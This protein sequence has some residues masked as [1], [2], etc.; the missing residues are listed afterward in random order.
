VRR[1]TTAVFAVVLVTGS[2]PVQAAEIPPGFAPGTT[3]RVSVN[4]AGTPVGSVTGHSISAN[5]RYVVFT[6]TSTNVVPG[7]SGFQVYRHDRTT[8]VTE[9]VSDDLD[10]HGTD[11]A[12][13]P[14]ISAD[15]R[16][17]AYHSFDSNI[18][19]GDT[20]NAQDVFVRDME[21]GVTTLVSSTPSGAFADRG[22]A[23][24]S[25]E[26]A[27]AISDD[28]RYVVFGSVSTNLVA[29]PA[30]SFSQV[31]RKDT[32]TGAVLRVSIDATGQP[33]NDISNGA[34]ISGN[35][36]VIA[37]IS[38]ASNFSPLV[39]N[40]SGQVYVH[41]LD[42]GLTTID[43]VNSNGVPVPSFAS[44]R[45]GLSVDGRYLVF[46]TQ[47]RMEARDLDSFTWDVYLRDRLD[48]TTRLASLSA[49]TFTFADS[50]GATISWDGRY[51]GFESID[52]GLVQGDENDAGD[53]FLYDRDTEN[54]TLVSL[55]DAGQQTS[56]S[57]SPSL[58]ADG[59]LVLFRSAGTNLV[60]DPPSTGAQLYVRDLAANAPPTVAITCPAEVFVIDGAPIIGT[61][62]DPDAG[63]TWTA[64]YDGFNQ[65]GPEPLE[66]NPDH[67]FLFTAVAPLLSAGTF[68][69]TIAVTD[70]AGRM[71]SASCQIVAV[72][73]RLMLYVHGTTGSFVQNRQN[74]DF[75]SL[76]D[77][78]YDSYDVAFYEYY[79]DRGNQNADG[80][81]K[82]DGQRPI[83]P[84]DA[85]AGMPLD[86]LPPDP[87]PG[88][89]DSNDDVQLNAVR[90]D[91]DIAAFGETYDKVTLLANSG[92]GRIV[93]TYL[94]YAEAA[95]RPS[96]GLVDLVVTLQGV[97]SGTYIAAVYDGI[98]AVTGLN[99]GLVVLR[100]ALLDEVRARVGHDPTRP[101]FADMRPRSPIIRYTNTTVPVP[102]EPHY[103]NVNGDMQIQVHQSFLLFTYPTEVYPVGDLVILVGEDDPRPMP[104][105]G[106]ARFLPSAAG[107][108]ASSTEWELTRVFDVNFEP[109][110]AGL[111][112][113]GQI[114][115]ILEAPQNHMNFGKK[116]DQ[117]CAQDS[118][119]IG[120]L[121]AV[122]FDGIAALDSGLGPPPGRLGLG[123]RFEVPCP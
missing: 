93:R 47:A 14:T 85:S 13:G 75:P 77:R 11:A 108:G 119:G 36:R 37:F 120:T 10:G 9:L 56:G 96:L 72:P 50:R 49:N 116:L 7:V 84:I 113:I 87:P 107:R 74:N 110:I 103:I 104:A 70:S 53:V 20:N 15:G 94:A 114:E 60:A 121:D 80:T 45:P 3:T 40:H 38:Q 88:I 68:T 66:L 95:Q 86:P 52:M 83:P 78:L 111:R 62:S 81:C 48:G 42:T 76:F 91:A 17:I 46:E 31:Y 19:D 118:V 117:I 5:G 90:L 65:A 43:A 59:T 97:Q 12:F 69:V 57:S 64:T 67:T 21:S 24:N 101:A 115:A 22:G 25:R 61:F 55:N 106:G 23:L 39:T 4:S 41:D 2:L 34:V 73:K 32:Q 98:D 112:I 123:H 18:V 89:C 99:P 35:G 63:Q 109:T 92:G 8:G 122:I 58:S 30:N 26:A 100:D 44:I 29:E 79:E 51:V 71:G 33:G 1:V 28:G 54:I 82:E 27:N 102:N 6:S 16:H 105:L